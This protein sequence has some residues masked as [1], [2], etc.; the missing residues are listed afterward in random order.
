MAFALIFFRAN[1]VD[2]AFYIAQHIFT[3]I[4]DLIHKFLN[5]ESVYEEIGLSEKNMILSIFLILFLEMVHYIQTKANISELIK[6]KPIYIRWAIY[7]GVL[8]SIIFL[9][10]FENRQFIYFQF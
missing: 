3:G 6:Q 2:S 9:G 7:Y 1:S 8:L 5:H 10:V 4:P